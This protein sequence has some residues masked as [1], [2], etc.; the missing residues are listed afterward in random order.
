MPMTR[1]DVIDLIARLDLKATE[2][3]LLL[4]RLCSQR[5]EIERHNAQEP[6]GTAG[7]LGI[8]LGV[9]YRTL[10]DMTDPPAP[11]CPKCARPLFCPCRKPA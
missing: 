7:G 8:S 5:A 1:D 9:I 3:A 2:T 10:A 6:L 11:V 4:A